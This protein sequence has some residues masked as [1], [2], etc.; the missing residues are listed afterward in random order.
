MITNDKL[1]SGVLSDTVI[2]QY[3]NNGIYIQTEYKSG[4][5]AFDLDKQLQPGSI[6]L[7]FRND[8]N[9]FKLEKNEVLSFERIRNKDY[10]A[11]EVIPT[12][13]KLTIQPKEIILTTTLE[14]IYL[15]EDFAAIIT[16]RSSFARLG[17]MV[18]CCQDFVNPGLKN[19]VALQLINLSP[20]PI[21]LDINT[22]ICQLVIVKMVGKPSE[23]YSNKKGSKYNGEKVFIPSKISDEILAEQ[24]AN[25][26]TYDIKNFLHRFIEPFLPT[27]IGL[28]IITPFITNYGNLDI[29]QVLGKAPLKII[30][31][32]VAL[33]LYIYLKKDKNK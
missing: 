1:I 13:G 28:L 24:T 9:R 10:L 18:Q 31:A 17:L 2:R 4:Q 15:S 27:V 25:S 3:W 33:I 5:L 21:E 22:P 11:P 16:G 23:G 26:K 6:D 19:S 14:S 7:R 32:I 8:I 12:N 30:I 20:Y 29:L